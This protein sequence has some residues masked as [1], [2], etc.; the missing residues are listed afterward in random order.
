MDGIIIDSEPMQMEAFEILMKERG[1]AITRKEILKL[2]GR[3]A[4]DNFKY[5]IELY[6][7]DE[8]AEFL[9]KEKNR[10]YESLLH[11]NL[12]AIPGIPELVTSL[13]DKGYPLGLVSGSVRAHVDFVLEGLDLKK[14]FGVTLASEDVV[15]G[16]PEPEGF[17]RAAKHLGCEPAQS[18]V[19]EDTEPGVIAGVRGGFKVIAIPTEYTKPHDFSLAWKVV[20][21]AKEA[22][23][24]MEMELG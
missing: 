16:K 24:L 13:A 2:V 22:G 6:K 15:N 9:V 23:K 11:K 1:H 7:L 20:Q 4:L 14:H 3:R 5:L 17:L 18:Y 12:H 10:I 8:D 19:L 21:D